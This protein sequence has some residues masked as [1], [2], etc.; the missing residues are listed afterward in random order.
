[1]PTTNLVPVVRSES[2]TIIIISKIIQARK[3][4]SVARLTHQMKSETPTTF[5]LL[6][7]VPA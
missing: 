2:G 1:M 7:V 6:P 3:R 4:V 5:L